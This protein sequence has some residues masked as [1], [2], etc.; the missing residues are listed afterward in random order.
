MC[1]FSWI[2]KN[3][4]LP[5]HIH[6]CCSQTP[7]RSAKQTG[8]VLFS[9]LTTQKICS[10]ISVNP[11]ISDCVAA[12]FFSRFSLHFSTEVEVQVCNTLY[13]NTSETCIDEKPS[14]TG[15]NLS[16]LEVRQAIHMMVLKMYS[17][18]LNPSLHF[19]CTPQKRPSSW[20]V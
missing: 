16:S 15:R 18:I 17:C 9:C 6:C 10:K 12:D 5:Q 19:T 3:S 7:S 14:F 11:S 1:H 8:I 20:N 2:R 13:T 4:C